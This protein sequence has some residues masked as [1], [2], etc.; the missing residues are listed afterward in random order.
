MTE[1]IPF[2]RRKSFGNCLTVSAMAIDMRTVYVFFSG[3]PFALISRAVDHVKRCYGQSFEFSR[4]QT[5][6]YTD[7]SE[8]VESI[9]CTSPIP[10]SLTK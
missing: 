4:V 1:R 10:V 9:V 3:E 8:I 2:N 5:I 6:P 7:N